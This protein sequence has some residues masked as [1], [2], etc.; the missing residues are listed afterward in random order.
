MHSKACLKKLTKR[1]WRNKDGAKARLPRR[2]TC[3]YSQHRCTHRLS[4]KNPRPI[5]TKRSAGLGE[6]VQPNNL[7]PRRSLVSTPNRFLDL[8]RHRSGARVQSDHD[9]QQPLCAAL[10]TLSAPRRGEDTADG[11]LRR[12]FILLTFMEGVLSAITRSP[13]T[14]SSGPTCFA[15]DRT[16]DQRSLLATAQILERRDA[17]KTF[18]EREDADPQRVQQQPLP[19]VPNYFHGLLPWQDESNRQGHSLSVENCVSRRDSIETSR[20]ILGFATHP[21]GFLLFLLAGVRAVV[22]IEGDFNRA[23]TSQL[24]RPVSSQAVIDALLQLRQLFDCK[25][26]PEI[27]ANGLGIRSSGQFRADRLGRPTVGCDSNPDVRER[28]A[29]DAIPVG[30]QRQVSFQGFFRLTQDFFIIEFRLI[31]IS[32]HGL[33][34]LSC[35]SSLSAKFQP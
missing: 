32:G 28:F 17:G 15:S 31:I 27:A 9:E 30:F 13:S 29:G 22:E 23:T 21:Q 24:L 4:S 10:A 35:E 19:Q 5:S 16:G 8:C 11:Q 25:L 1:A 18:L 7:L 33:F 34:L 14:Q 20:S 2:A 26:L 12:E 6:V 3:V